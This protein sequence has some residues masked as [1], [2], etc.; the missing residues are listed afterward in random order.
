M[1]DEAAPTDSAATPPSPSRPEG[2]T[3]FDLFAAHALQGLLASNGQMVRRTGNDLNSQRGPPSRADYVAT[4]LE[5][6]EYMA[7]EAKKHR[8]RVG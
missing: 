7:S 4:A 6:A 3:P 1:S 2:I 8:R 5:I